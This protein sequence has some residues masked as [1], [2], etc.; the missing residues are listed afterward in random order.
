MA[1]ARRRRLA[2]PA[3]DP[4]DSSGARVA[5]SAPRTSQNR[6]QRPSAGTRAGLGWDPANGAGIDDDLELGISR[7]HRRTGRH[8]GDR[9]HRGGTH[10]RVADRRLAGLGH[11]VR[12]RTLARLRPWRSWPRR[13]ARPLSGRGRPQ[14]ADLV[15]VSIPEKNV[16]DLAPGIVAGAKPGAPVIETN[17]YYP[18]ER[19][20]LIAAIEAGTPDS[21][22]VSAAARCPVSRSS[23]GSSGSTC[24]R[25]GCRAAAPGA[26]RCRS[27]ATPRMASRSSSPSSTN[28]ALTRSTA[29]RWPNPGA[30]SRPPVYGA[31]LDVEGAIRALAAASERPE[32]F[33]AAG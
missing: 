33:R 13:P 4:V 8:H 15:M 16:V 5:H 1:A 24:S 7:T 32:A 21:V 3:P 11:T 19:D 30:S 2:G 6:S 12:M 26:S 17:N 28:S 9:N 22:S 10:R 31:D 14:D 18:R 20:G 29:G 23:T 25:G 27:P